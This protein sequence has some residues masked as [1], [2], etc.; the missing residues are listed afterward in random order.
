MSKCL[1][2]AALAAVLF[3]SL[4]VAGGVAEMVAVDGAYVRAVPPG[5]SNSAAFMTLNNADA[6]EHQLVGARSSA[7]EVVELHTHINDNG[8]MRMRRVDSIAIPAGGITQLQPGGLHVMLIGLK[9]T[10][11]P[12]TEVDLTLVYED[13]SETSRQAPVQR[14][15]APVMKGKCGEGKC[16]GGKCGSGK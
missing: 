5:V 7:A 15:M 14:V 2:P 6:V 16:G 13:G 10:L 12:D 4:S 11:K 9:T 3:S 8:V 1:V